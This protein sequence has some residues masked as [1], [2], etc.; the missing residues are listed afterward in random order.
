MMSKQ[1]SDAGFF[2]LAVRKKGCLF[3]LNPSYL[4]EPVLTPAILV[5]SLK[6][7]L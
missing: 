6:Y 5:F 4:A 7:S 3:F 1:P 2:D